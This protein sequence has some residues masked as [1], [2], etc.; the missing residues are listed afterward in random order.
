MVTTTAVMATTEVVDNMRFTR[1][2][3]VDMAGQI[4]GD[5]AMPA[6][7]DHDHHFV[8][9]GKVR[10]A[11]VID[12]EGGSAL[13]AINDETH[14]VTKSI[15]EPTG[16]RI[17]EVSFPNDERPFSQDSLETSGEAIRISV[18]WVNFDR[19]ENLSAF[20]STVDQDDGVATSIV[21]R[22]SLEPAPFIQFAISYP[23]LTALLV[24]VFYRGEK[25]L[26]YTVDETLRKVGADISDKLSEK[27]RGWLGLYNDLRTPDTREVTSD[28]II[29]TE[30]RIHLLTRGHNVE[31]NTEIGLASLCKQLELR[32]DLLKDSDSITFAR[33]KK[34]EEWNFLYATTKSGRVITTEEW[35]GT[36]LDRLESIARTKRVCLCLEHKT[37]KEERHL[38]TTAE[39]TPTGEQG[40]YQLKFNSASPDLLDEWDL[41]NVA[42]QLDHEQAIKR[43]PRQH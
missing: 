24:W 16:D 2:C 34:D 32:Q 39:F 9:V 4:N 13:Q 21:G 37:T 6:I 27:F 29:D 28:L 11:K 41:I 3:L 38:E 26:R 18:D 36:T 1:E 23:E 15:H 25:F 33:S 8:P 14:R 20:L 40:G 10:A 30:P 35:H 17:V 31:E 19:H 43:H 5:K 42:L 7:V 22:R 12:Y